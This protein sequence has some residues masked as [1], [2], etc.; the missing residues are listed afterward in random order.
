MGHKHRYVTQG[1]LMS[2]GMG[3]NGTGMGMKVQEY[4]TGGGWCMLE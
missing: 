1:G 4:D 3:H 2:M